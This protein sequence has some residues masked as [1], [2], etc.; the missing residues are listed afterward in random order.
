MI[1]NKKPASKKW[2]VMLIFPWACIFIS[3]ILETLSLDVLKIK[4][5]SVE[6][7]VVNITSFILT[8]LFLIGLFLFTPIAL[9]NLIR[10][11]K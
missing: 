9:V 10:D 6:L 2:I 3:L 5:G 4:S 1:K 7:G 8:G 11:S